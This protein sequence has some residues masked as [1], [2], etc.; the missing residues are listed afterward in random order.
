MN[1]Y[2]ISVP[3]TFLN[4][5]QLRR[6]CLKISWSPVT[7]N[8]I[9]RNFLD[10]WWVCHSLIGKVVFR[11]FHLEQVFLEIYTREHYDDKPNPKSRIWCNLCHKEV[12]VKVATINASWC[13][14][15]PIPVF[16]IFAPFNVS[17]VGNR[18]TPFVEA[19]DNKYSTHQTVDPCNCCQYSGHEFEIHYTGKDGRLKEKKSWANDT[20]TDNSLFKCQSWQLVCVIGLHVVQFVKWKSFWGKPVGEMFWIELFPKLDKSSSLLIL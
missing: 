11:S 4:I 1:I 8:L 5:C 9:E 17:I 12:G 14:N 16:C 19:S 18:V 7:C 13:V 20:N 6:I 15:S 2:I 3:E 10:G